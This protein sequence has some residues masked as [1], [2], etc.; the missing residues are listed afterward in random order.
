MVLHLGRLL[1]I[2][3]KTNK[4]KTNLLL[5]LPIFGVCNI[6]YSFDSVVSFLFVFLFAFFADS[7]PAHSC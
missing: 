3:I 1:V 6:Y 2:Y 7:S 5:F 4:K